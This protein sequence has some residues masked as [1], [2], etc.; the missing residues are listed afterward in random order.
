MK[1]GEREHSYTSIL[2]CLISILHTAFNVMNTHPTFS[3]YRFA[4]YF[5]TKI[6]SDLNKIKTD[7]ISKKEFVEWMMKSI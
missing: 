7:S 6:Y 5:Q 4:S 2:D 3:I 1:S